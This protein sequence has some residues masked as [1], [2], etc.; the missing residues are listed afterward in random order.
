MGLR[1]LVSDQCEHDASQFVVCFGRSAALRPP[2]TPRY[3]EHTWTSALAQRADVSESDQKGVVPE[4]RRRGVGS[5]RYE[6][7][8]RGPVAEFWD[9]GSGERS[10]GEDGSDGRW[11][12]RCKDVELAGEIAAG[13]S[14]S[15]RRTL[16]VGAVVA[17]S[18]AATVSMITVV[19]VTVSP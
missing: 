13:P 14:G 4:I 18:I 5:V 9:N 11:F 10:R 2:G 15:A 17:G 16:V 1:V 12:C 8:A 19:I 6:C 7:A 3:G